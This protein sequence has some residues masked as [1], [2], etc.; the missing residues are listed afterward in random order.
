[1]PFEWLVRE[2][3]P[4]DIA[5]FLAGGV[6][7]P[8]LAQ[9]GQP[10]CIKTFA[11]ACAADCGS[12][13]SLCNTPAVT[14]PQ[15]VKLINLCSGPPTLAR[16]VTALGLARD[17]ASLIT[18]LELQVPAGMSDT[19]VDSMLS[20]H[21]G[22][23]AVPGRDIEHDVYFR[24]ACRAQNEVYLDGPGLLLLLS[25]RNVHYPAV[26]AWVKDKHTSYDAP[27]QKSEMYKVSIPNP[28]GSGIAH[29]TG[30]WEIHLHREHG[31]TI[32][33][34]SIKKKSQGSDVGPG[35]YRKALP[36][37]LEKTVRSHHP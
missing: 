25:P 26:I 23:L 20:K 7:S 10:S 33:S 12:L 5:Q 11:K 3:K 24:L 2:L 14:T 34:G 13:I 18:I 35:V 9:I 22:P 32:S 19:D 29:P 37:Q 6:P 21:A 16:V 1:V 36:M 15:I 4:S 27:N 17:A 30:G 31:G 28:A 8:R